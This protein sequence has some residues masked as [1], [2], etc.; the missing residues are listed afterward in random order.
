LGQN[1][2]EAVRARFLMTRLMEDWLDL[3]GAFEA[4]FRLRGATGG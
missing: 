2:K 1:A 4:N 3:I